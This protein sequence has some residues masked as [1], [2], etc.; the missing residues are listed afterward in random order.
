MSR[1]ITICH[2]QYWRSRWYPAWSPSVIVSAE[3]VD[4]IQVDHHLSLPKAKKWRDYQVS[5]NLSL[6]VVKKWS[7]QK[8]ITIC[9]CTSPP[10]TGCHY[11]QGISAITCLFFFKFYMWVYAQF[12]NQSVI[13]HCNERG[14]KSYRRVTPLVATKFS[15][16]KL[17]IFSLWSC[18]VHT[19]Y[20]LRQLMNSDTWYAEPCLCTVH[21]YTAWKISGR[22]LFTFWPIAMKNINSTRWQHILLLLLLRTCR[23]RMIMRRLETHEKNEM[24]LMDFR[25]EI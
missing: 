7:D 19:P 22:L 24:H 17:C 18:C 1:L 2:C 23:Y 11:C 6:S 3:G 12:L 25:I 10:V 16:C 9:H 21:L 8:L 20:E 5:H 4:D 14:C 15:K 13:H